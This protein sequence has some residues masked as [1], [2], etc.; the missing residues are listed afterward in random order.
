M[1]RQIEHEKRRRRKDSNTE[2]KKKIGREGRCTL[3]RYP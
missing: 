1:D 3:A 2:G